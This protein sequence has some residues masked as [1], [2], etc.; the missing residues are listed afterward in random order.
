MASLESRLVDMLEPAV[1]ALG[2]ELWGLEFI[3]A[4]KHSTLR[5]YIDHENGITVDNCADCSR[6][7]SSVLDVEDPINKEYN[8]EVSSPGLERPLFKLEHYQ[9][10]IGQDLALKTRLPQFGQRKFHGTLLAVDSGM[11]TLRTD[12]HE[13]DLMFDN[14]DKAHLVA[15]F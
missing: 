15:K 8:L 7:I 6:Q 12:K 13:V 2:F 14:I 10:H 3:R 1:A 4:G 11:I 9:A 5:V